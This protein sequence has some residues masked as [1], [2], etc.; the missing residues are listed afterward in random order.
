ME[1]RK[2]PRPSRQ[3]RG[4]GTLIGNGW[5]REAPRNHWPREWDVRGRSA[6]RKCMFLPAPE[7]LRNLPLTDDAAPAMPLAKAEK[8]SDPPVVAHRR[9]PKKDVRMFPAVSREAL[10][11]KGKPHDKR[12][13]REPRAWYEDPVAMG[14]LLI[15]IPPVGLAALWTSK[16]YSSDARWVL[17]VMTALTMCLASAVTVA[18][19]ALR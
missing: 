11:G 7:F 1:K 15:L 9:D 17:T 8:R 5:L 13:A 16:R 12:D 6:L 2:T 18:L 4:I 14:A 19:V 3:L 10:Y